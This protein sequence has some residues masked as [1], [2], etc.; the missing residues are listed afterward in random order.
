MVAL[1]RLWFELEALLAALRFDPRPDLDADSIRTS[2]TV[3]VSS[4]TLSFV[5]DAF[6][7]WFLS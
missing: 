7:L 3:I 6:N 1:G 4:I 2:D 5:L